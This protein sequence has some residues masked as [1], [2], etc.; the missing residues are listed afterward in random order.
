MNNQYRISYNNDNYTKPID[1]HSHDFYEIY[2]FV[3]GNVT[4]YI[5]NEN[6]TLQKG[7]VLIIPPGKLHRPV[8]ERNLSYERY[9]LWLYHPFTEHSIESQA[10]MQELNQMILAKNQLRISFLGNQFQ[11][12]VFLFDNL[13]K[14]F[15]SND[16]FAPYTGQS[17]IVLIVN[18]LLENLNAAEKQPEDNPDVIQQIIAYINVNVAHAPSLDALSKS[19]YLSKYYLAHKFKERTNTTLHKYILMKKI[20]MAKQL[21]MQKKSPKAVCDLCGFSTYSN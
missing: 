18:A 21:L 7:D 9:V 13:L 2:F 20:N 14:C 12:A 1:F 10:L 4:Y 16:K 6:Y 11:E 8:I 17:N 3:S 5:E 15:H 19:F